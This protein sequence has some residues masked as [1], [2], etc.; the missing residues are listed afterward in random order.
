MPQTQLR[1]QNLFYGILIALSIFM[2]TFIHFIKT[3]G[4]VLGLLSLLLF[5]PVLTKAQ[6]GG[7]DGGYAI[8][9]TVRDFRLKN[10]DGSMVAMS[11]NRNAKGYII[12]FTSNHCPFSKAYDARIAS[13]HD[14]FASRGYGVITIN[15]NDPNEYE[16]DSFAN[17]KVAAQTRRQAFPYLQ[18]ETQEVAKAFGANRTPT[19]YIVKREGDRFVLEYKGAID[20]NTQD[21]SSVS[22]RFVEDA[23]NSLLSNRPVLINTTRSVGCAIKWKSF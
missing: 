9:Q 14:K 7:N 23:L 18:D 19:A 17:M 3:R 21:A 20:D 22:Q 11:D 12:I 2:K 1:V 6:I 16:E 8:G 13:L 10:I 4:Y 15:S 5:K